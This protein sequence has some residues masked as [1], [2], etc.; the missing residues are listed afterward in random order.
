MPGGR[1][2]FSQSTPPTVK[3]PQPTTS[4]KARP[5]SVE[6]ALRNTESPTTQSSLS[7]RDANKFKLLLNCTQVIAKLARPSELDALAS[8]PTRNC[9]NRHD[10]LVAN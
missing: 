2:K 3:T 9:A 6:L 4:E 7:E 5:V 1:E 10:R 8:L